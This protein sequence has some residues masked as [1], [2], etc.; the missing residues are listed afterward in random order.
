[1]TGAAITRRGLIGCACC[2]GLVGPARARISPRAMTPL[3]QAGYRPTETDEKGLWQQYERI[4]RD[5]AD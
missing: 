5:I 1:M 4:E 2:A 3:V